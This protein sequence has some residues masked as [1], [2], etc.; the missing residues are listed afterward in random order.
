M[1]G[2]DL[3]RFLKT[4]KDMHYRIRRS[5]D[6][7]KRLPL[8]AKIRLCHVKIDHSEIIKVLKGIFSTI[9]DVEFEERDL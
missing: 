4:L 5:P 2:D 9:E 3:N 8:F 6:A 1:D 7:D